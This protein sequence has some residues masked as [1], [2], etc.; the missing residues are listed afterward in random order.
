MRLFFCLLAILTVAACGPKSFDDWEGRWIGGD[1]DVLTL[2]KVAEG[3]EVSI[4]SDGTDT[5][6]KTHVENEV[7]H[8]TR[9]GDETLTAGKGKDSGVASLA[10][11]SD[12]LIVKQGEAYCRD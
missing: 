1:G 5:A 2:S 12:C 4:R 8:F 11:K 6:Y 7:F 10:G 3:Y 9:H